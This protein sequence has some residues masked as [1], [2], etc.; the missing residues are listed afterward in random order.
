MKAVIDADSCIYRAAWKQGSLEKALDNY[1]NIMQIFWLQ[2]TW[3]DSRDSFIY[4][5]G[6]GNFRDKLVPDYKANRRNKPIPEEAGLFKPLLDEIV[7]QGLAIPANGC[8]A[9]DMVRI[10]CTEL[11]DAD[12]D[13]VVV[14]IDK[15]LDCIIGQHYNPNRKEFYHISEDEADLHY[16]SQILAGDPTDS[17]PG[18]PKIGKIRAK[19]LL[20]HTPLGQRKQRVITLYKYHIGA[21]GWEEALYNTANG[22]HI[23]RHQ[24]DYF[25][26]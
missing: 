3:I 1:Q 11:W 20:E 23:W 18:L 17:L 4:C 19:K 25:K 16:Y 6:E 14:H 5:A 21:A 7:K 26:L 22:V 15:D 24:D 13:F 12:E 10:K 9:D 2:P 8:E